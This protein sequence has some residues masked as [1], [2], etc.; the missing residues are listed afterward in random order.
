MIWTEKLSNVDFEINTWSPLFINL[1][2]NLVH[3]RKIGHTEAIQVSIVETEQ[4]I[5]IHDI[6]KFG[7][8]INDP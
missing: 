1:K 2:T 5:R 8:A 7:R 4:L 3:I 6:S